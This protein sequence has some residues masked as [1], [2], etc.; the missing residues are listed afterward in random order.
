[1]LQVCWGSS[2]QPLLYQSSSTHSSYAKST[3]FAMLSP[4]ML[5][6]C[7]TDAIG[8][9]SHHDIAV[10]AVTLVEGARAGAEASE[11]NLWYCLLGVGQGA[12]PFCLQGSLAATFPA[13]VIDLCP[14]R[15]GVCLH[16]PVLMPTSFVAPFFTMLPW[17]MSA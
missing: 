5:R 1:M 12:L 4:A 15:D 3:Q 13:S 11:P 6:L 9:A 14:K 10:T 8:D 7:I 17:R 2:I 16:L